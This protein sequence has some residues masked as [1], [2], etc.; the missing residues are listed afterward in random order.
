[1]DSGSVAAPS[2]GSSELSGPTTSSNGSEITG[3]TWPDILFQFR[4][5]AL[6]FV[7]AVVIVPPSAALLG[8]YLDL[9]DVRPDHWRIGL[10]REALEQAKQQAV[11]AALHAQRDG[12][13]RRVREFVGQF[14]VGRWAVDWNMGTSPHSMGEGY[15]AQ[16]TQYQMQLDLS[17]YDLNNGSGGGDATITPHSTSRLLEYQDG[18]GFHTTRGTP[19]QVRR[20]AAMADAN[21][22]S[23]KTYKVFLSQSDGWTFTAKFIE[24]GCSGMCEEF[25]DNLVGLP[26]QEW[27]LQHYSFGSVRRMTRITEAKQTDR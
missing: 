19:Q 10:N 8:A 18:D 20:C 26:T 21:T 17:S 23:V 6:V 5:I 3:R 13:Q 1:M 27:N 4:F 12:Y 14:A 7:L 2:S 11:E 25:S 22:R 15:C 16:N 9:I 24:V